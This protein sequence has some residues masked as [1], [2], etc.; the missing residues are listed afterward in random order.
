MPLTLADSELLQCFSFTL[1]PT[2]ITLEYLE[3]AFCSLGPSSMMSAETSWQSKILAGLNVD[4]EQEGNPNPRDRQRMCI[5]VT[6]IKEQSTLVPFYQWDTCQCD[7]QLTRLFL[8]VLAKLPH[9][10]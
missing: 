2:C 6:F 1:W 7:N 4:R 8:P 5:E 9:L 10:A 3:L